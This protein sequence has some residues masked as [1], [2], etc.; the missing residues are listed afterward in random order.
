MSEKLK[1][2]YSRTNAEDFEFENFQLVSKS[3]PAKGPRRICKFCLL[4]IGLPILFLT[5]PLYMRFLALRPHQ[6]LLSPADMKL[7]NQEST[8][9][10]AWCS[11]QSIRM[12]SSFNAYLLPEKPKIKRK[13]ERIAMKRKMELEDDT[14]EY[15]GFYLLA[16]SVIRVQFCSRHEGA[17]IIV[18]KG[19]KDAAKCSWLG[20]LDSQEEADETSNEFDFTEDLYTQE[21]IVKL[22]NK[23]NGTKNTDT[24][25]PAQGEDDSVTFSHSSEL[26]KYMENINQWSKESKRA[27]MKKLMVQLNPGSIEKH[28]EAIYQKHK[29]STLGV[30]KTIDRDQDDEDLNDD[31]DER[32]YEKEDDELE[33]DHLFNRGK[34]DQNNNNES[35]QDKSY[36]EPNSSW[37]SSEE[38]LEKCEGVI[39]NNNLAG[40]LECNRNSSDE[41]LGIAMSDFSYVVEA[42]GFYYFIFSNDNEITRNFIAANFELQ[43]TVFDVSDYEEQCSN[44][45]ICSLPLTF[46]STQHVVIEVPPATSDTCEYDTEGMTNYQDCHSVLH[47]ELVCEPRGAVY[48]IFLILVP[49]LVLVFA[50]I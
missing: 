49:V 42:S 45:T 18:V 31:S 38:A 12:N 3:A 21:T 2:R 24:M 46:M 27:L 4:G 23:V 50:N 43:K 25:N 41:E 10:T 37:S 20:E 34:F 29:G 44:S 26:S 1:V 8:V 9:S 48:L 36:E 19:S 30:Y 6:M 16:G 33:I 22:E 15:W 7:L 13:R 35:T 40:Q 39:Y 11:G 5:V 17:S 28:S 32:S 14:K 47:A